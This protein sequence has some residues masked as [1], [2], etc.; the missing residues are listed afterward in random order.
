M[1]ETN[2]I[3]IFNETHNS[4]TQMFSNKSHLPHQ[5]QKGD[6]NFVMNPISTVL[7]NSDLIINSC[8]PFF[9]LKMTYF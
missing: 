9:H 4:K 5:E 3:H 7:C 1:I 6:V 2:T 8:F